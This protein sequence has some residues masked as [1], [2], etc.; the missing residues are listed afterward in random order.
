MGT[1]QAEKGVDRGR[2]TGAR[3]GRAG[4]VI[5]VSMEDWDEVWR[6]NQFLCA[7][8]ARRFPAL[9]I[10]FVGVQRDV[11]HRLKHGDASAALEPALYPVAGIPSITALKP[12]KLLPNSLGAGRLF[13]EAHTRRQVR[14][15]ARRVGMGPRPLLWLNPHSAV[16]M[17]GRMGEAAVV[18]DITDDWTLASFPE[19]ESARIREQDAELCTRADL[20]VVCSRSL[21]ESRRARSRALLHLPN[22]VDL[23]HYAQIKPGRDGAAAPDARP[24]FG[25]VGTLHPDRVDV[26]LIAAV[27]RAFPHGRV[28]LVGPDHLGA[29]AST[30]LRELGNVTLRGA[31]PY[32]C[33]PDQIDGFDVCMV[34]HKESA[35]TDSLNPI[36]LWEY[37]AAGRPIV[38]SDVAGFR[39]YPHLCRIASGPE[40][41]AAACAEALREGG[42]RSAARREEAARH[43]WTRRAD[44]LLGALDSIGVAFAK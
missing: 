38:S 39:D 34:P 7:E 12:L 22:G 37:L 4:G 17:A 24:V 11:S 21:E 9:P 25:Y 29:A 44:D 26:G 14:A 2:E 20:V 5:F 27:A 8:L 35:F 42:A 15:A 3:A 10:L 28:V 16:H 33:V 1:A 23:A 13:N 36:K 6:R 40:A 32:S 43:S 19:P 18:Y 41:F 31:V 30:R